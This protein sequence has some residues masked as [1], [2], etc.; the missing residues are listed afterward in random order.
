MLQINQV[1]SW[2][3]K[4]KTHKHYNLV[5]TESNYKSNLEGQVKKLGF[6]RQS[7]IKVWGSASALI[8]NGVEKLS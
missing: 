1:Y 6:D 4:S 2:R 7:L 5:K 8:E 3:Y